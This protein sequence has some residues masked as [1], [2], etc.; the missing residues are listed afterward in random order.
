MIR[1]DTMAAAMES[2]IER[3][4][5]ELALSE[6]FFNLDND[7]HDIQKTTDDTFAYNATGVQVQNTW[8]LPIVVQWPN[9]TIKFRFSTRPGDIHFGKSKSSTVASFVFGM[10]INHA[11]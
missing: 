8:E 3:L 11:N 7:F 4:A 9:S 1:L 10:N 2:E 5:N 6:F